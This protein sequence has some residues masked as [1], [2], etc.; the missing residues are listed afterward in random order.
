MRQ[1]KKFKIIVVNFTLCCTWYKQPRYLKT[2]IGELKISIT[3]K[4]LYCVGCPHIEGYEPGRKNSTICPTQ[5]KH[6]TKSRQPTSNSQ[7]QSK[8]KIK[9]V[10]I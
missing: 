8:F 3:I 9:I 5:R 10:K 6:P 1:A 7:Q 4:H 2:S